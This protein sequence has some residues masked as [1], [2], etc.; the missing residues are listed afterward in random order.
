MGRKSFDIRDGGLEDI[1]SPPGREEGGETF[2][3][4]VP[5]KENK[6]FLAYSMQYRVQKKE[7]SS[8][9]SSFL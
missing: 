4:R 5:K 9:N 8:K 2:Y 6:F 1:P 3:F 7:R